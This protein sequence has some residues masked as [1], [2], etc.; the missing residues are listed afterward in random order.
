MNTWMVM[1]MGML[2]GMQHAT[3]T[4]HL[5]AV[6]TLASRESSLGQSARHGLAWGMG[7]G[8]TLATVAGLLGALGW[9]I[10]PSLANQ[11]EQAVGLM[12]V[13]LGFGVLWRLRERADPTTPSIARP[14][15]RWP[16]RSA[17]VGMVHGLAGSA[18]LTLLVASTMPTPAWAAVYVLVFALGSMVGMALLSGVVAWPMACLARPTG[19]ASEPIAPLTRHAQLALAVFSMIMGLRLMGA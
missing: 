3:E 1:G 8:L 10:P 19:K 14:P 5:A 18:A 12:L 13:L 6:A 2:L 16:L 4:D 7:H 11:L 15:A 9:V 17:V